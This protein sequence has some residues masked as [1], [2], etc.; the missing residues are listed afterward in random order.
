MNGVLVDSNILI[1]IFTQDPKW[2]D[3]SSSTLASIVDKSP[4]YI[5]KIIYAEV[6][7][8]FATI[9]S[10]EQ[11]LPHDIFQRVAI[12][13]EAA[14]LAGKIFTEYRRRGGAKQSP[15]PDFYIGAHALISDFAVLTRDKS[16]YRKYFPKLKLIEPQSH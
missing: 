8:R 3:W 14:F 11:V 10:L 16:G 2:Y 4:I 12:P 9:E 13:W 15:L 6:S 1:D 7:I 5:N